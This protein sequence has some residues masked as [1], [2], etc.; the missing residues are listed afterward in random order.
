[1]A[2]YLLR[3]DERRFGLAEV[4]RAGRLVRRRFRSTFLPEERRDERFG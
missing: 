2:L 3:R 1:V 4:R